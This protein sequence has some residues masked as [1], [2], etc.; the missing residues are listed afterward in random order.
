MES[1]IFDVYLDERRRRRR[2]DE[3]ESL[4]TWGLEMAALF[5]VRQPGGSGFHSGLE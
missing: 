2:S 3:A 1:D 4:G 5:T